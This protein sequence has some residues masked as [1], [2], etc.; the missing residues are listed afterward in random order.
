MLPRRLIGFNSLDLPL[1]FNRKALITLGTRPVRITDATTSGSEY[2]SA[3]WLAGIAVNM[4]HG[5]LPII[6]RNAVFAARRQ[7]IAIGNYLNECR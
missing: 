6:A 5:H 2:Q 3:F 4:I 7:N 1:G